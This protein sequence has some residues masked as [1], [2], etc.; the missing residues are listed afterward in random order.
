M[1]FGSPWTGVSPLIE[2][3]RRVDS[4]IPGL[5]EAQKVG[6]I[7]RRLFGPCTSGHRS[8]SSWR[9]PVCQSEL[10]FRMC[11]MRPHTDWAQVKWALTHRTSD[12]AHEIALDD[13]PRGLCLQST[14]W[15]SRTSPENGGHIPSFASLSPNN[16]Q[17]NNTQATNTLGGI[18]ADSLGNDQWHR[19]PQL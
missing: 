16:Q 9:C 19:P 3:P 10:Q 4:K 8:E 13:P 14:A 12:R 2:S 11:R 5:F 1:R 6:R 18:Y 15:L 17:T 7:E